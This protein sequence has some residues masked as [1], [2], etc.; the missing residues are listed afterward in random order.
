MK[1][2]MQKPVLEKQAI[3]ILALLLLLAVSA[4]AKRRDPLTEVEADQLREVAL[5]PYKRL[6]LLVQFTGARLT[7]IEQLR[8]DP[9]A[10]EGRGRRIHDLLEDFT[11]LL[12]TINDNL[13]MY[14]GRPLNKDDKKE[15]RKGLKAVVEADDSFDLKLKTLKAATQTDLQAQKELADFKF[16][17]QD[18]E[19]ALQ[20]NSEVAH[21]YLEEKEPEKKAKP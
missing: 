7:S 16:V 12:D 18:A 2:V 4:F 17:L 11:S 5:E 13:D 6:K 15:F 14:R 3:K 19:E 21:E 8:A 9:A 10:A 1:P 20:S